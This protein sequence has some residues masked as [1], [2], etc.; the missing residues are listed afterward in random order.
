MRQPFQWQKKP[1]GRSRRTSC[2]SS[3][4]SPS[5][6]SALARVTRCA[7]WTTPTAVAWSYPWAPRRPW[8]GPRPSRWTRPWATTTRFVRLW[9]MGMAVSWMV[10]AGWLWRCGGAA[11]CCLGQVVVRAGGH[12][13]GWRGHCGRLCF[14]LNRSSIDKW[15]VYLR[16]FWRNRRYDC[17][18]PI[19]IKC[20]WC[21]CSS[22]ILISPKNR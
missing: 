3:T 17:N 21:H 13:G 11:R 6:C 14:R 5:P 4:S 20:G 1:W 7:N 15:N 12:A 10:G 16:R 19:L 8:R 2:C 9:V 18:R 22:S